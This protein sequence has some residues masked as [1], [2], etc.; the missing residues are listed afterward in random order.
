[1]KVIITSLKLK[2]VTKL[3]IFFTLTRRIDKQLEQT[4]CLAARKSGFWKKYYTMTLWKN[5][6]DMK[7][8][9]RSGAH[10]E[11]M[12]QTR[13]IAKDVETVTVNA[14]TFPTWKQAKIILSDSKTSNF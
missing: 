12:K 5:E 13:N 2:S 7:A 1:M 4:E 9:A 8:F 14:K 11:A 10:L 3:F 6:E